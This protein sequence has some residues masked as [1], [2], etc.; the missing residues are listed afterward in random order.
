[1]NLDELLLEEELINIE[2]NELSY[3]IGDQKEVYKQ[4]NK[5]ICL[6]TNTDNTRKNNVF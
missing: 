3:K 1:M 2:Q 6:A 5:I 4:I